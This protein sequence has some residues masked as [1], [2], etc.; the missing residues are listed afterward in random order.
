MGVED[1]LVIIARLGKKHQLSIDASGYQNRTTKLPFTCNKCGH[2]GEV[3]YGN[4]APSKHG[5][6]KC[7]LAARV[8]SRRL[9]RSEIEES[10]KRNNLRIVVASYVNG[11]SPID[12]TCLLCGYRFST[13]ASLIRSNRACAKCRRKQANAKTSLTHDE[14]ERRLATLGV[15][16]LGRYKNNRAKLEVRFLRCGHTHQATW[17]MLQ[18]GRG[19]AECSPTKRITKKDYYELA[20]KY[21]GRVVKLARHSGL[22]TVW[23]CEHG[24]RFS[25]PYQEI[26][27]FGRFCTTCSASWGEGVCRSLMELFFKAPFSKVRLREMKSD[28]GIPLELDCYNEDLSIAVEHQGM[29]HYKSQSNWGGDKALLRQSKHDAI[30]RRYCRKHD[31][32]LIEVPEVETLTP[33]KDLPKFIASRLKKGGRKI[34]RGMSGFDMRTLEIR[35]QRQYYQEE[36]LLAAKELGIE[37]LEPIGIADASI[38]MRCIKKGHRLRKTPRSLKQGHG[39][40]ECRLSGIKKS[41]RLSDGRVFESGT[42]AAKALGVSKDRINRAARRGGEVNG[43]RVFQA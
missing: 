10:A 42:A 24:H 43:L 19:C 25:R 4:L 9:P 37:V 20:Q 15:V 13:N 6:P 34:P 11:S 23:E 38:Q 12:A 18:R 28:K 30:R 5:C 7:A 33:L 27:R 1:M 26:M 22:K 16:L 29:H 39:C 17:N 36:I 3:K 8:E 32:L 21:G 41:V 40:A 35:S 31:I 2:E 14:V